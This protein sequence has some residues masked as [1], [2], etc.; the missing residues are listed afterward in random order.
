MITEALCLFL[1][2]LISFWLVGN[3]WVF[4]I[5]RLHYGAGGA[6]LNSRT[7]LELCAK[8]PRQGQVLFATNKPPGLFVGVTLRPEEPE[9]QPLYIMCI[10]NPF[11]KMFNYGFFYIP[12]HFVCDPTLNGRFRVIKP[13]SYLSQYMKDIETFV[14]RNR[15]RFSPATSSRR[16]TFDYRDLGFTDEEDITPMEEKDKQP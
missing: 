1:I 4:M 13:Q 8:I 15:D 2:F 7:A 6:W 11:W 16:F 5:I 10:Q 3:A 12:T 9:E 14:Y